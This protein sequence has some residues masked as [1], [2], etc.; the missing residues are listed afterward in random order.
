[1][2]RVVLLSHLVRHSEHA[3][4]PRGDQFA[5]VRAGAR[6]NE[7]EERAAGLEQD[8]GEEQADRQARDS[9][10]GAGRADPEED[11]GGHWETGAKGA[12]PLAQGPAR[13][14]HDETD[15]R[16]ADP[17]ERGRVEPRDDREMGER[18]DPGDPGPVHDDQEEV[19]AERADRRGE[20]GLPGPELE[21]L[22][23]RRHSD[24]GDG[25]TGGER[26]EEERG[27]V[28]GREPRR[29]RGKAREVLVEEEKDDPVERE[30]GRNENGVQ[31]SRTTDAQLEER[32]LLGQLQVLGSRDR[33]RASSRSGRRASRRCG[34]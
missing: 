24:H 11:R 10:R 27:V 8:R 12:G 5:L 33:Y 15:H 14:R 20:V 4:L 7:V 13:P 16:H 32:I 2:Q 34:S 18:T 26:D 9:I 6:R 21:R 30:G 1:M 17:G 3:A 22:P 19:E 23:L 31:V 28:E 29:R 25:E